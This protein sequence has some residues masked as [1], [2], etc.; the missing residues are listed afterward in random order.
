[1]N[2][3]HNTTG[4]SG[5]ALETAREAAQKQDEVVMVIFR[6]F[7]IGYLTPSDV[8]AYAL[9]NHLLDRKTP[10]TS[11]RRSM[12]NLTE[13]GKLIKTTTFRRSPLGRREHCWKLKQKDA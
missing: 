6:R 12:C 1:M 4:L 7:P 5:A 3:F 2:L 9:R 11:V 10:I 8:H 13:A